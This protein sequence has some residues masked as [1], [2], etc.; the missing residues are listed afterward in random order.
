VRLRRGVFI[1]IEDELSHY[2]ETI[3]EIER[4][5]R[6][7]LFG[8]QGND[9]ENIGGGKSNLPGDPTGRRAIALATN[10]RIDRMESIIHAID[11]VYERLQ[12]E[13]RKLIELMYWTRPR[14][15]TWDG[16]AMKLHITRRTVSRWRSEVLC[17]IASRAGL[18]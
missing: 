10:T 12:P 3:K 2:N 13:K 11:S 18:S 9:D 7:I 15:Y 4:T 5:K 16:V 1:Y 14:N 17:A 6:D 8:S